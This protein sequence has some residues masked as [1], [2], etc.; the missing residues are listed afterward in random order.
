MCCRCGCG[1]GGDHEEGY[2]RRRRFLTK[3]ER[4]EKLKD[5]A[6]ELKKE[7]EAVQEHIKEFNS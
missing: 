2:G 7:L 4:L 6:G 3:E 5:Y 1:C